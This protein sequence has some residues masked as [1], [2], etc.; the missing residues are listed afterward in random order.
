MRSAPE[1]PM[2]S[3]N[4]DG[5]LREGKIGV[6]R[7]GAV[8]LLWQRLYAAAFHYARAKKAWRDNPAATKDLAAAAGDRWHQQYFVA[9]FYRAV[10]SA[11]ETD[12]FLVQ[13]DIKELAYL[14]LVVADVPGKPRELLGQ[15]IQG[16]RNRRGV[17]VQLGRSVGEAPERRGYFDSHCHAFLHLLKL[18]C[19]FML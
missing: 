15:D 19:T 9:S 6:S 17:T 14:A 7:A 11:E 1:N 12:V 5:A 3:C 16:L 18:T 13:I 10:F 2:Q 4:T 8:S